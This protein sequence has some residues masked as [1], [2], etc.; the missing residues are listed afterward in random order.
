MLGKSEGKILLFSFF[1]LRTFFKIWL[2][3]K[4]ALNNLYRVLQ[5][6]QVGKDRKQEAKEETKTKRH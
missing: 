2:K 1:L 6:K 3:A 5:T 4:L